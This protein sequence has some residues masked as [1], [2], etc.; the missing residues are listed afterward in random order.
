MVLHERT[1]QG[2]VGAVRPH[3]INAVHQIADTAGGGL[4]RLSYPVESSNVSSVLLI[5]RL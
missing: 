1:Q 4:K 2:R 3:G 5:P